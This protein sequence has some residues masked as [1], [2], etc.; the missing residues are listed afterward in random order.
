MSQFVLALVSRLTSATN[1]AMFARNLGKL[2]AQGR[3]MW[4]IESIINKKHGHIVVGYI[5]QT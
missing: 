1:G 5:I 2:L 4:Y 3:A